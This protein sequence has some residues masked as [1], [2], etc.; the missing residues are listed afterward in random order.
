[1]MENKMMRG[2][3]RAMILLITAWWCNPIYL[4]AQQVPAKTD[5]IT[6]AR[7]V[8][9]EKQ[10]SMNKP[11][12]S[13][14]LVV[15][16]T[17]F[18]YTSN[19]TVTTTSGA[20]QT[21][22][23]SVFGNADTYEFSP[24]F[25]FRQGKN[26]LLEFEPSFNNNGVGVNWAAI[27][28]FLKP[29]L[30][31]RGGYFVLPFGIYNKKLAA[32]WINKMATD[33]I[34]MP[35][36]TDY[37]IGLSGGLHMG[38]MKWNYDLSAT[39]G[40]MLNPDGTLGMVNQNANARNK[41]YTGR[42]GLLPLSDNSLEI[43]V[44]GLSGGVDNGQ[45]LYGSTKA[46]L[47]AFDLNYVK[48]VSPFQ[49]NVKSQYNIQNVGG[50]N[51]VNPQDSSKRYTFNNHSTSAYGQFSIRPIG[52]EHEFIKN[53]ELAIRYGNYNT[54]ANS[55]WGANTTQLDYGINYWINWRTVVRLT[56]EI[57][58]SKSTVN[59]VLIT[60]P[61]ETKNYA[62]HIQFSVQL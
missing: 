41:T 11:G 3:A 32:G 26:L 21:T 53:L 38:S 34:G 40:M 5:S 29:N 10:A 31:I 45:N 24:M 59:P 4:P 50:Q 39:N 27:S 56:Y 16:L 30:I 49:L 37:G 18:G 57:L 1:M 43:G 33:P 47:Y 60:G 61:S 54:P 7:I 28:Y 22:K 42:L 20:N 55:T 35:A 8:S 36:G 2:L 51:Y 23:N 48:N 46:M 6:E 19:Q 62:F 58:D 12:L 13:H 25:L 14:L 44:S 52:A 9:L 17:T 15:G